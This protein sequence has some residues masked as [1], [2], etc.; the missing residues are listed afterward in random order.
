MFVPYW[1]L[2]IVGLGSATMLLWGAAAAIPIL[3][4]V[5][6]RRHDRP[7]DWGAMV[8]LQRA[9][10]QTSRRLR[11][12]QILLLAVRMFMLLVL[13]FA[14]ADPY[15]DWNLRAAGAVE[16]V[17]KYRILVLDAS[18]SMMVTDQNVSCFDQAK[19]RAIE[20]V[21]RSAP[22]DAFSLIAMGLPTRTVI[23]RP[24]FELPA[25]MEEIHQ[26]TCGHGGADLSQTV[27]QL[28][29]LIRQTRR[30][31][32]T[33]RACEV[34][35]F[36]DL[37]R[38][39][40]EA[41]K[42]EPIATRLRELSEQAELV[43]VDLARGAD[44]NLLVTELKTNN[45]FVVANQETSLVTA[46]ENPGS[47][48]VAGV[49]VELWVEGQNVARSA[50][51]L[52]A[53]SRQSV[54]FRYRFASAGDHRVEIRLPADSLPI[55]SRRF[56][57]VPVRTAVRCLCVAGSDRSAN[58]VSTALRPTVAGPQA[59]VVTRIP[60][61]QLRETDLSAFDAVFL[62]SVDGL[63]DAEVTRINE[64]LL[65]GGGLV[66]LLGESTQGASYN[67]LLEPSPKPQNI[68]PARLLGQSPR[69]DYHWD[70]RDY[71]YSVVRPFQGH[72]QSGLLT[73][74]IWCYVRLQPL[75]EAQVGLWFDTGEPAIVE[76]PVA[77]GRTLLVA[78]PASDATPESPDDEFTAWNAWAVWPSFPP[79]MLQLLER[80]VDRRF[81][82]RT[83]DTGTAMRGV[84][85]LDRLAGSIVVQRESDHASQYLPW[86]SQGDDWSFGD[87]WLTGFYRVQY[88]TASR[89]DEL[90]AVNLDPRESDPETVP[91]ADLD[92]IFRRTAEDS[93]EQVEGVQQDE[94]HRS[95]FRW[96]LMVLL[97][98]VLVESWL[99][100]YQ[101]R[102]SLVAADRAGPYENPSRPTVFD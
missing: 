22:G 99:S 53:H 84:V 4:H 34:Y 80:A 42:T 30:D 7:L 81:E 10:R 76:S 82:G 9:V 73:T 20:V 23:D 86:P 45:D 95:I 25:V 32:P 63:D 71:A 67:R 13:A 60:A 51:Q 72:E 47:E 1:P 83:V 5:W 54:E 56:L 69:G 58:F 29:S 6:R 36:T 8:F 33:L 44:P 24:S 43:M 90:Y 15:I 78:T 92:G 88:G 61:S 75:P 12:Q 21:R 96:L 98:A 62:C 17:A 55:D 49:P 3:L 35:W 39:T 97:G 94:S 2:A 102:E 38:N 46:I 91:W 40:W 57:V 48:P 37:C 70:P 87:T 65:R 89:W 66:I 16:H 93:L 28:D 11:M 77:R 64:L 26:L 101:G 52:A 85:P 79:M 68:L 59:R 14:L 19:E 74:P 41:A 31:Y 27:Q 50:V 100:W 18:Y